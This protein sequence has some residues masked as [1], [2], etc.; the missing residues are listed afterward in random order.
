[1][2]NTQKVDR[3]LARGSLHCLV[4]SFS[5][6]WLQIVREEPENNQR[7]KDSGVGRDVITL[8]IPDFA[9]VGTMQIAT[10]PRSQPTVRLVTNRIS[11]NLEAPRERQNIQQRREHQYNESYFQ[12]SHVKET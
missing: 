9:D 5:A 1:M 4:R 10:N 8:T 3:T 2:A 6:A 7:L 11:K 12:Y